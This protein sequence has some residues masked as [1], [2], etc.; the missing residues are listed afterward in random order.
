MSL[1]K[2]TQFFR[3]RQNRPWPSEQIRTASFVWLSTW[4]EPPLCLRTK[5]PVWSKLWVPHT[6]LSATSMSSRPPGCPPEG[7]EMYSC[8][9]CR[10]ISRKYHGFFCNMMNQSKLK[11]TRGVFW[12]LTDFETKKWMNSWCWCFLDK[13]RLFLI[14]VLCVVINTL[15]CG[16]RANVTYPLV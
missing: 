7:N 10:Q 4:R 5:S 15:S 1:N 12:Q 16:K 2:P 11:K 13:Y 6:V 3:S 9:E 14:S 8:K